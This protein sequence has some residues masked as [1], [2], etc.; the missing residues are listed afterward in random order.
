M[1]KGFYLYCIRPR[2]RTSSVRGRARS[3][4]KFSVEGIDGGEIFATPYQDLEAIVS[5][6]S[7]EEF[8]SEE[9]QKKA[10]ENLGWIKE[11]AFLHEKVIE[12]AMELKN[13]P[14]LW[15]KDPLKNKGLKAIIPMKFGT[16][17]K[18]KENLEETFKKHYN[19]FKESLESL[20]RKQEWSVKIYLNRKV[21]E[22]EIKKVS[23]VVQEKEKEIAQLPE[24]MAYFMQ[25]QIDD[26]VS[27]E[28]DR[29]LENY[30]ENFFETLKK[31]A[32]AG[33]KGKILEKELTGR[34]LPMA[35]NIIFLVSEEKLEDFIKEINKL[36]QEYKSKGF[37]FEYSGPWPPYN[38][39]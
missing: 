23:E 26:A 28:A 38:F 20:K 30:T 16:I 27:K 29:A 12:E 34:S 39:I 10:Q 22:E 5:E 7:L 18:T 36:N 25:K 37:N 31:Y 33:S 15:G 14:F 21:F 32:K 9:I 35:L 3:E 11:K 8:G 2:T 1:D 4:S 24:G 13:P 19:Q 6:V 17:F